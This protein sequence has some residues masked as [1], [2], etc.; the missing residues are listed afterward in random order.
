MMRA[1]RAV[2]AD[3]A[4]AVERC[5]SCARVRFDSKGIAG[6]DQAVEW[7]PRVGRAEAE[8]IRS[9][10]YIQSARARALSTRRRGGAK[11]KC[12]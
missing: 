2:W 4:V 12:S 11:M 3:C 7:Q 10:A 1:W 9:D 5:C 6:V 8:Q